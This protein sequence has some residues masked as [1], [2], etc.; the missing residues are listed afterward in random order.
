MATAIYSDDDTT[1]PDDYAKD[2][3]LRSF[4]ANSYDVGSSSSLFFK[5]NLAKLNS[6]TMAIKRRQKELQ[7]EIEA[8]QG[9]LDVA[10]GNDSQHL[11][12]SKSRRSY[13]SRST[14]AYKMPK[15][16]LSS[17]W[18]YNQHLHSDTISSHDHHRSRSH[19]HIPQYM[20]ANSRQ[21][22][23]TN[24]FSSGGHLQSSEDFPMAHTKTNYV[25]NQHGRKRS[26][27]Q[28]NL[29][30]AVASAFDSMHH[31]SSDDDISIIEALQRKIKQQAKQLKKFKSREQMQIKGKVRLPVKNR[32]Q[33]KASHPGDR[34]FSNATQGHHGNNRGQTKRRKLNTQ[35]PPPD[36]CTSG[37]PD[38]KCFWMKRTEN[39]FDDDEEMLPTI[40]KRCYICK[41]PGHIA[42]KCPQRLP[43]DQIYCYNCKLIGHIMAICPHLPC[44][45]CKAFGHTFED[46]RAPILNCSKCLRIGHET[47]QCRAKYRLNGPAVILLDFDVA[48][49]A[50][51]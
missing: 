27:S 28:S 48:D 33:L 31:S 7:R 49:F 35:L 1:D 46:C 12:N 8:V 4:D 34:R 16:E 26:H 23:R 19:M 9:S 15:Y 42:P 40:P 21:S 43:T 47:V 20:P 22:Y 50:D 3:L 10:A 36:N 41:R 6:Q 13:P 14:Q 30:H 18:E 37:Q 29:H 38:T 17:P 11:I 24:C 32:L 2:D 51:E 25:Q 39:D 5:Q 45:N 44:N